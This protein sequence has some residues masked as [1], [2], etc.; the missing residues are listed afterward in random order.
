MKLL[1]QRQVAEKKNE[2]ARLEIKAGSQLAE[3]VDQ[4][5]KASVLEEVKLKAFREDA[6]SILKQELNALEGQKQALQRHIDDL[7]KQR[8]ELK[9]PLDEE[10]GKVR[11]K[12][13]ELIVREQEVEEQKTLNYTIR[14]QLQEKI[15]I[16]Q[17]NIDQARE[18]KEN[19]EILSRKRTLQLK[20]VQKMVDQLSNDIQ[21][22][23]ESKKE[24]EA[25]LANRE[26]RLEIRE[27]QLAIKL[28]NLKKREHELN[29]EY[30]RNRRK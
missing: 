23:V 14:E 25:L 17:D 8:E 28:E 22:F 29:I 30:V 19:S 12:E 9:K 10:W 27:K 6:T 26:S 20:E 18:Y 7:T 16:A 11:A 2:E 3:R 5:R 21:R 4:L 15:D 13:Q 1:S 24:Q